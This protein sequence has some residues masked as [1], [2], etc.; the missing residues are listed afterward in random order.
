MKPRSGRWH[1]IYS[2]IVSALQ[3]AAIAVLIVVVFPIFG[4]NIPVWGIVSIL[5]AYT[6]FAYIMYRISHP[7]VLYSG[8]TDP[9]TM[10][11]SKGLVETVRQSDVWVR[12][13]GEL[14][15]ASCPDSELKAG[16]EVIVTA[17]DGLSLTVRKSS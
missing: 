1:T 15:K 10:V 7:T 11:G 14:W 4:I 8:V 5:A 9:D 6:V 13:K 16:D 2:I 17:I 3:A 12:I